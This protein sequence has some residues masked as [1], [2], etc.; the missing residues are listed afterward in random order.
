MTTAARPASV[1]FRALGTTASLLVADPGAMKAA[2]R[3]LDAELAAIDAA[4]SRFRPDSELSRVNAAGGAVLQ[5]TGLFAEA[6]DVALH[7]AEQTDGVVDPTVGAAVTALGYDVT[8]AALRPQDVRPVRVAGPSPGRR[9]VEWDRAARRLRLPPGTALDLGA[10]A[11]ALAADRAARRAAEVADCGVLVNLGG[12]ISVAGQA[13]P[14]GWR[15]AI[16][17]DHA[18]PDTGARPTVSI[19]EGGLATSGTTVRTWRR[20]SRTLHHIVDPATG[21]V[22]APVWRTVSVAAASCVAANTA[23]TEAVVLGERALGRLS[24]AGL[25]ARLVRVDGTVERVCGWP[26]D[27]PGG[28]R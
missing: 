27:T 16:A 17:D 19:T 14:G 5:V 7:A 15:V 10:T 24:R 12:D 8:F 6:L 13:P 3:V 28:A 25:P 11:K 23:G 9:A 21:D 20:G 4:C 26:E 1:S 2:R 22:P 18:A